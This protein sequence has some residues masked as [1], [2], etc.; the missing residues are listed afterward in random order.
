MAKNRPLLSRNRDQLQSRRAAC[1]GIRRDA[2]VEGGEFPPVCHR[3][4][5]EVEIR[6]ARWRKLIRAQQNLII[7]QIHIPFTKKATP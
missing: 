4:G 7:Q 2:G 5:E 3:E 6:D 1:H